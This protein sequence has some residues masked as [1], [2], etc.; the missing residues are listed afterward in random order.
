MVGRGCSLSSG[1]V[2]PAGV[3]VERDAWAEHF[4]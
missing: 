4:M 1:D 2:R 3:Q